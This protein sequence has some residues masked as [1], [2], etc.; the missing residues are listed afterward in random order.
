M[1]L[2]GQPR[3]RTHSDAAS[4]SAM[5]WLLAEEWRARAERRRAISLQPLACWLAGI[6]P[7]GP[8]RPSGLLVGYLALGLPAGWWAGG[9]GFACACCV[10]LDV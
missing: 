2:G 6:R 4:E 3:T 10:R 9:G 8:A 5:P 7:D 1:I